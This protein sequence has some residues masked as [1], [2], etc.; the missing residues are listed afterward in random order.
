MGITTGRMYFKNCK[1]GGTTDYSCGNS[2]AAVFDNC[3]LYTNAG[4]DGD[5]A[6]I[7]APSNPENTNGDLFYNCHIT[8]SHFAG[9]GSSL[10]RPWSG[11]NAS[12]NYITTKIDNV[13]ES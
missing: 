10:G 1:I 13:S 7:T 9:E 5:D 12:A 11:V 6:T 8:G 2:P 3:E 4:N